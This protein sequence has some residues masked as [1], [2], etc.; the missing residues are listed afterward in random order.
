MTTPPLTRMNTACC[1]PTSHRLQALAGGS[2]EAKD[3]SN[4][5]IRSAQMHSYAKD[6]W[7]YLPHNM[8][9]AVR[10]PLITAA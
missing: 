7:K 2:N 4:G 5:R 9:G 6:L 10:T 3:K 8:L 1:G